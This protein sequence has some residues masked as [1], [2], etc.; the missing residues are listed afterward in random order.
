M[1]QNTIN[2]KSVI[3]SFLPEQSETML[4]VGCGPI[5]SLYPYANKAMFVTCVDWKLL[6]I[7]PIPSNLECIEGDFTK[8]ELPLNCYDTI[9]AI[10]VFEHILLED[11]FSFV[12]KCISLLKPGGTL[13]ISVPNKGTFSWLDPYQIKPAIHRL[14]WHLG[15]YKRIHNGSCDIRKGHKHYTAEEIVEKFKSLQ[16]KEVR[17]W[18]YLFDPLL[19]WSITFSKYIYQFPGYQQLEHLC[20]QEFER[21]YGRRSFNMALK[22]CKLPK[23]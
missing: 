15:I 14:L 4:D 12:N 1:A 5:N 6:S 16:L 21:N 18:G 19:S 20:Q 23:L 10:D 8:L 11:E 13:I 17:Y 22:F 9:I 2:R 7:D 3:C